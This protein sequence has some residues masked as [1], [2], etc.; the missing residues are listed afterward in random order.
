[1]KPE[2]TSEMAEKTLKHANFILQVFAPDENGVR[3][4]YEAVLNNGFILHHVFEMYDNFEDGLFDEVLF[5][6]DEDL[7]GK[8][9][10]E[11]TEKRKEYIETVTIPLKN[12]LIYES[13]QKLMALSG[14]S[15]QKAMAGYWELT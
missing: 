12:K 1:M 3:C 11:K 13:K 14:C 6:P 8:A 15:F 5:I 2:F 4:V 9:C 7:Y 10:N